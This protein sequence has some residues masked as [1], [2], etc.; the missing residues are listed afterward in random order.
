MS[1]TVCTVPMEME[2][3]IVHNAISSF[4]VIRPIRKQYY[5]MI[6]FA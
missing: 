3:F 5:E 4:P 2:S 1:Q 6:I